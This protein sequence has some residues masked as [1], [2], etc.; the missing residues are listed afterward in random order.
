MNNEL[1]IKPLHT[2]E[3]LQEMQQLEI[4][5][6]GMDCVPCHQSLTVAK[7]GGIIL[8]G[9]LEDKLVGFL[10]SFPGFKNQTVYLCSHMLAIHPDYQKRGYGRLLK[11]A[12]REEAIKKGFK[13]VTWTFDPLESVNA[14]LN[15][16]KLKAVC[17][18][19]I[20]NCYGELDGTLNAGLA[21][22]RF[23]VEWRLDQEQEVSQQH[24]LHKATKIVNVE[25][26]EHGFTFIT[27]FDVENVHSEV[28]VVPIPT[29]FQ[30]I[31]VEDSSLAIDWRMKTREIFTSLFAQGYLVVG[32]DRRT[33]ESIQ[34]YILIKQSN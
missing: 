29:N 19:Y 2:L 3:E 24:L 12:Q 10:Y 23:M 4:L 20:E 16:G 31:K 14:N 13:L 28:V 9:Y 30:Q 34:N 22:D 32:I 5:V 17:N 33:D 21:T 8:G 27:D 15:I 7:N 11:L 26:N 6:W 18:T 1:I 25:E